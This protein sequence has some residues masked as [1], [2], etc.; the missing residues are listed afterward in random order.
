VIIGWNGLLNSMKKRTFS[1]RWTAIGIL[2]NICNRSFRQAEAF[3][4]AP[5]FKENKFQ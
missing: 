1:F 4:E 3:E 2:Q 5:F